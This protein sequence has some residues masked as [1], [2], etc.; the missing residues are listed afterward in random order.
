MKD[1]DGLGGILNDYY[2]SLEEIFQCFDDPIIITDLSNQ[3][4][5][6]NRALSEVTGTNY[7]KHQKENLF[8][9]LRKYDAEV[10]KKWEPYIRRL[11]SEHKECEFSY[12]LDGHYYLIKGF[13]ISEKGYSEIIL[14]RWI[15]VT[16]QKLSEIKVAHLSSILFAIRKVNQVITREKNPAALIEKVCQSLIE[17]RG[18]GSVWVILFDENGKI[19]SAAQGGLGEN[20]VKLLNYL[21]KG[22]KPACIKETIDRSEPIIFETALCQSSRCPLA[23]RDITWKGMSMRL[24]YGGR[25]MGVMT[26]YRKQDFGISSEEIELFQSVAE[27]VSFALHSLSVERDRVKSLEALARTENMFRLLAENSFF[28]LAI[29]GP[30]G[31]FEYVNPRF[32]E[33]TGYTIREIPDKK[34]WLELAYPDPEYRKEML[35]SWKKGWG[36]AVEPGKT[37]EGTYRIRCKNGEVKIVRF[38]SVALEDGRVISS[39][40]DITEKKNL[41]LQLQQSQK[42]EAI[43][44]LAGGIAHDFNNLLTTILGMADL[45]LL[46]FDEH[47][48]KAK[49]ILEIRKAAK[50]ASLLTKQLLAFSRRQVLQ[51][52][53]INLNDIVSEMGKMLRRLIGE[54][55]ELV[56][57]LEEN[58][59]N[60][61][62]DQSQIEQVIMNLA[63]NARDAMP[64][65]GKLTV[66]TANVELDATYSKK[67]V[68]VKPGS[69]VMLAISDT[70][71]GMDEKTSSR[72]FEPFFTTKEKD[73]GTGLGLAMVYGIVKQSGGNIWVYSEPGEGTTFKI[74]FPRVSETIQES[75]VE[76]TEDDNLE[77]SET[78]LVVEDEDMVRGLIKQIL[79]GAGYTVLDAKCGEEAIEIALGHKE[80]I[81]LVI[82]DVVMPRMSG[83][84]LAERLKESGFNSRFLY[85]SGYT[86]NSIVHHGILEPGIAF[87]QKPF[88]LSMLLKKVREV[89]G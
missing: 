56:M 59:G 78:V 66:E 13:V 12:S 43:G 1:S 67:H 55:I 69:Y 48:P 24:E 20:F 19:R 62:V 8:D 57:V 9:I 14:W 88:S 2:N 47:D 10:D 89:L 7:D 31:S 84:E 73:K 65:G 18:F 11:R 15:D 4:L 68:G 61:K 27:D 40:E 79:S 32:T 17:T 42:M 21:E 72:I 46:D 50:R 30:A 75:S 29:M 80:E 49:D 82:T 60:V 38:R 23:K 36:G 34:S 63:V 85:I 87:I 3:V 28:G 5:W 58:L 76:A 33:I 86:D 44:R 52:A 39:C 26:V 70:G 71:I 53:I 83:K 51:P 25:S 6:F 77:G 64:N 54:D 22:E 81:D 37:N 35:D 45:L 41:Q 74:Y 16:H